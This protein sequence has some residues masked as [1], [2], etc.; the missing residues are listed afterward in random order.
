MKEEN[1]IETT[2]EAADE[3]EMPE[4]EEPL[5][6]TAD[7]ELEELNDKYLRLYADF[8]NYKKKAARDKEELVKY[9]NESMLYDILPSLDHL[10]IALKHAAENSKG[11]VEGVQNTLR[12]LERTLEKFGLKSIEAS[13]KPFDPE[14]HHAMSQVQRDD[15]VENTVVEEFRKGY[16]YGDKVLRA[17]LV[18][19]SKKA[20]ESLE[21]DIEYEQED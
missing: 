14:F 20:A 9:A 5:K 12:E 2:E 1:E 18:A 10:A 15:V 19:V 11:L 8:E 17:S 4:E 16:M 3:E 21:D 7:K 13:G 6:K